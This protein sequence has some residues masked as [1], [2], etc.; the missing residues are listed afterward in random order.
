MGMEAILGMLGGAGSTPSPN[1]PLDPNGPTLNEL[2]LNPSVLGGQPPQVPYAQGQGPNLMRTDPTPPM[3]PVQGGPLE[4]AAGT[5]DQVGPDGKPVST[6]D[7]INQFADVLKKFGGLQK[8]VE[9]S[10]LAQRMFQENQ[11]KT[12]MANQI[13]QEKMAQFKKRDLASQILAQY[14]L[15]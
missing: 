7:R 14:G 1:M 12:M 8:S 10:P 2:T 6:A 9:K 15:L 4:Q 5:G 13:H 3:A 11:Q